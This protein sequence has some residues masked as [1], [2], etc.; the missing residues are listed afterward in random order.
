[1]WI[2]CLLC[3]CI[4]KG[5]IA[6]F[7]FKAAQSTAKFTYRRTVLSVYYDREVFLG[8]RAYEPLAK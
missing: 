4:K 3:F 1:M 8:K 7:T 2:K 5:G 6:F